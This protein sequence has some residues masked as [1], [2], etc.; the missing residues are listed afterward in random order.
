M[1]QMRK[2]RKTSERIIGDLAVF[3]FLEENLMQ[4][5]NMN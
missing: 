5:G 3:N 2:V 4:Y 1:T